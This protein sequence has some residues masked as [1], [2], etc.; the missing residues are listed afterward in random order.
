[1]TVEEAL[2]WSKDVGGGCISRMDEECIKALAEEVKRL[3]DIR[4]T[5]FTVDEDQAKQLIRMATVAAA[6]RCVEIVQLTYPELIDGEM[7]HVYCFD[8]VVDVANAIRQEF[9]L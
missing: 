6:S 3:R 8:S 2:D 9:K 7:E 4:D 5:A 1:M